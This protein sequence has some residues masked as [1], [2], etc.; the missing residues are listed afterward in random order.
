VFHC[1]FDCCVFPTRPW[2]PTASSTV[3]RWLLSLL[4]HLSLLFMCCCCC[5]CCCCSRR[6]KQEDLLK[7]KNEETLRRLT[8][9][10]AGAAENAERNKVRQI[11][12]VSGERRWGSG[13]QA[14]RLSEYIHKD[15]ARGCWACR[16]GLG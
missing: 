2:T 13:V 14:V 8:A 1:F 12:Q 5:C 11:S 9:Q 7:Q 4:N 6:E 16:G 15:V 3:E 10:A